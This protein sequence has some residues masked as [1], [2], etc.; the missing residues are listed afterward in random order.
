[1]AI[2]MIIRM[3]HPTLRE[4]TRPLGREE[5]GSREVQRLL[6]DM[7]DTLK[8]AGGIG[9]AAP[10]I[11][12]PV[13]LAIIEIPGGPSRYGDLEPMPLRVFINPTIDVLD[14][15]VAGYWEG[16][17]S[18]PGLRGFVERP[19]RVKVSF[20]NL[21]GESE[22]LELSGFH[23]TVVQHELDHLFGKLFVDRISDP[24]K[25]VFEEE[26]ERYLAPP[27]AS[28]VPPWSSSG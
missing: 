26:Y 24:T 16:C 2:R 21:R 11:D 14:P 5:I 6:T 22:E 13:R 12:E 17:L 9:L 15:V 20:T 28:A 3:G 8:D 23:A 4:P 7:H 1:M 25:L 10:Q 27:R 19:Q 18:A